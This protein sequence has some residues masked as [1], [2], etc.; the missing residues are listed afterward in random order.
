MLCC[1]EYLYHHHMHM[2]T[3]PLI[4][5]TKTTYKREAAAATKSKMRTGFHAHPAITNFEKKWILPH[6]H[7]N[8][9]AHTNQSHEQAQAQNQSS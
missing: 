2:R 7:T 4:A 5:A 3:P 8:V 6:Q 1:R 9:A